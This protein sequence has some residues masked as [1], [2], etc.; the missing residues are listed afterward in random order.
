[1]RSKLRTNA[2]S[3]HGRTLRRSRAPTFSLGGLDPSASRQ[4]RQNPRK[5]ARAVPPPKSG[6]GA[7]RITWP[8]WRLPLGSL[9]QCKASGMKEEGTLIN[10]NL[11]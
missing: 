8:P 3:S 5:N 1:M 6:K 4:P 11:R 7:N 2:S 9:W 10:A